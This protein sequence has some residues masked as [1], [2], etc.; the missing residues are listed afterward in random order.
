M[1]PH[2]GGNSGLT[3]NDVRILLWC[4]VTLHSKEASTHNHL[5]RLVFYCAIIYLRGSG[6]VGQILV[7]ALSTHIFVILILTSLTHSGQTTG[8]YRHKIFWIVSVFWMIAFTKRWFYGQ[9][10]LAITWGAQDMWAELCQNLRYNKGI[11]FI[12]TKLTFLLFSFSFYCS[13]SFK[14]NRI[15]VRESINSKLGNN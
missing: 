7:P 15:I 5:F 3:G 10:Q 8:S 4:T 12:Q 1:R 2:F 14:N 9:T 13:Q 6:A 11:T